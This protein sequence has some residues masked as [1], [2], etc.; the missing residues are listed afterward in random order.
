M[1][2]QAVMS[3]MGVSTGDEQ[4]RLLE[5]VLPAGRGT[6]M[7]WPRP[8]LRV[9]PPGLPVPPLIAPRDRQAVEQ[10]IAATQI[11]KGE[12]VIDAP[13][14]AVQAL[15]DLIGELESRIAARVAELSPE[16]LIE[17]VALHERAAL[18]TRGEE[19]ALPARAALDH[20]SQ[21]HGPVKSHEGRDLALRAL[22][23]R[24]SAAPPTG[25][26]PL[27]QRRAGWLR[28]ATELLLDLGG[29]LE[30]LRQE[31]VS[32]RV[33]VGPVG[34][35]VLFD[36]ELLDARQ[37]MAA[38]LVQARPH[39]MTLEYSQWWTTASRDRDP[40]KLDERVE[41]DMPLL[42]ALDEMMATEWGMG[43]GDLTRLLRALSDRADQE[44]GSVVVCEPSEL[45][46]YI[47]K[48]TAIEAGVVWSALDRLVLGPCPDFDTS[49]KVHRPW[50]PNRERS[51][52]R[53]PLVALPDGRVVFST[54]QSLNALRYLSSLI[55][56]NRLSAGPA[57]RVAVGR[58]S[59]RL[60]E[61]FEQALR[62]RCQALGVMAARGRR[63]R[64]GGL[65]LERTRGQPI[66]DIDVL[67][68]SPRQ[69]TVWLLDAKRL[70]SALVGLSFTREARTLAKHADHHEERLLWV[71]AHLQYLGGEIG[72]DIDTSWTIQ[73]ALVVDRPLFGA[74]LLPLATPVWGFWELSERLHGDAPE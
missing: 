31:H 15:K 13:D 23:E 2:M 35:E 16:A 39:F 68:W 17:L 3:W 54:L 42:Q 14:Q 56:S 10:E 30:M 36:E 8:D 40:P 4:R 47:H 18:Q 52:L 72:Y 19:I 28:A 60:D 50:E 7:L 22:I 12:I 32:G 24:V 49:L 64:L 1:L 41:F 55:E 21:S 11:R 43:L 53:R 29:N 6:L 51:Y 46:E 34:V 69:R 70:A 71:L 66:G 59:Q 63:K 20:V 9:N 65:P 48:A 45:V 25:Q 38:Q 74:H 33:I 37:R 57:I 26:L 27:S 62:E 5:E 67:A 73:A 58:V 44:V 61:D